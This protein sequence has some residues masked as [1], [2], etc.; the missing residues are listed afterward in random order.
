MALYQQYVLLTGSDLGDRNSNLEM[1]HELIGANIG[2]VLKSSDILE[3]EPWG[4]ESDTRF[5]NQA[6]LVESPLKP[7]EVLKKILS[8]EES[9]G[10]NRTGEQ[11]ISRVIDIDILCSERNIFHT[12]ELTIPHKLL[13]E[14]PFALKPLCQL[15]DWRHP[16]LNRSYSEILASL[17]QKPSK[18]AFIVD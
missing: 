5:L 15:V 17:T 13:H 12:A 2:V 18:T 16:L 8:I 3:S 10:R 14:R 9:I 4:F 11:W 7:L 1:A 6:L